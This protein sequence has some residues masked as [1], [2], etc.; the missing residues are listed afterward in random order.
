MSIMYM[1]ASFIFYYIESFASELQICLTLCLTL[2]QRVTQYH[3]IHRARFT[4]LGFMG[5]KQ[6]SPLNFPQ[7]NATIIHRAIY[8]HISIYRVNKKFSSFI[9]IYVI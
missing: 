8:L 1:N 4:Q 6:M 5:Q 7:K 9:E 2:A 3:V